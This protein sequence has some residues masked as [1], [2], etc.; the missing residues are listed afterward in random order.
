MLVIASLAAAVAGCGDSRTP[1]PDVLT[2]AAP[3]GFRT[4]QYPAAGSASAPR[5]TGPWPLWR[6]PD[7]APPPVRGATLAEDRIRLL[8]AARARDRSL[9]LLGAA[10]IHVSAAPAVVLDAL[11]RIGYGVREVRSTHVYVPGAEVVLEEYA[12]PSLWRTVDRTVFSP[13]SDSLRLFSA[14]A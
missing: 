4:L 3:A 11:E 6:F 1:V 8:R 12:P 13:L 14:T 7:R 9:R 5:R 2:P 10:L